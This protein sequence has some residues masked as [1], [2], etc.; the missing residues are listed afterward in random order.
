MKSRFSKATARRPSPALIISIIALIWAAGGGAFAVA[1]GG[2]KRSD[3][4]IATSVFKKLAPRFSVPKGAV[5]FF[6]RGSCPSGW[7]E[8]TSAR[9]RYLVGL[10][11]GGTL[12]GTAGT[13]LTNLENRATGR[14]SHGLADPGHSHSY[15][16]NWGYDATPASGTVR[17]PLFG[18]RPAD[19]AGR[20]DLPAFNSAT[21]GNSVAFA[22]AVPGTNAPYMQL[23]VCQKS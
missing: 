7:R 18:F 14:H 10:P 1:G 4:K 13:A 9:G 11:S 5:M 19:S 6:N 21:T 22:G 8:V 2:D 12:A 20:P 15:T 17:R 23:L 16:T 3:K